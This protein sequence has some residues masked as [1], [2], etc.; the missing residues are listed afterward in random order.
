MVYG[1]EPHVASAARTLTLD[2]E[3]PDR[4]RSVPTLK[5]SV[6]LL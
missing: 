2:E 1:R 4:R 6:N 3:G 5:A